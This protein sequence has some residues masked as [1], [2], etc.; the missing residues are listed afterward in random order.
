VVLADAHAGKRAKQ[1]MR[2]GTRSLHVHSR[3]A[4]GGGGHPAI[5]FPPGFPPVGPLAYPPSQDGLGTLYCLMSQMQVGGFCHL[6]RGAIQTSP[7]PLFSNTVKEYP[8]WNMCYLRGFDV[9]DGHSSMLYP[10]HLQKVPHNIYFMCQNAQQY[11][12][13]G[14]LCSTRHRHQQQ[15][16]NIR[17]LGVA[18][19]V[20]C[21]TRASF[22]VNCTDSSYPTPKYF[23]CTQ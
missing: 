16:P 11:I 2:W 9:A 12:D 6:P 1:S 8:N 18:Y 7:A 15:L 10:A 14:H 23:V 4:S 17:V 20:A 13:L 22:H 5:G 3:H 21:E 19:S